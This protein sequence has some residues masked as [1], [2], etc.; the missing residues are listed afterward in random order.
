MPYDVDLVASNLRAFRA[1]ADLSQEEVARKIGVNP[2]SIIN[3]ESGKNI[4]SF[5]KVCSLAALYGVSV[6]EI[7]G[8]KPRKE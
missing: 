2:S 1:K 6:D 5:E 8:E 3:W 7:R 4:P